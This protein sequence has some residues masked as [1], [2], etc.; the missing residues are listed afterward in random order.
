M[1]TKC[2]KVAIE[3]SK[4]NVLEKNVF[5]KELRDIQ[6]NSYKACNKAI[7]YLY[8]NDMTN[9]LQKEV[10]I[11]KQEDKELYGKSFGAWIE[12]RMNEYMPGALSSNVAQTRQFVKNRYENDKK[13]LLRGEISLS[14]FKRNMPILVHNNSYKIIETPKG[15]GIELGLFNLKKQ[16]E[17]GVKRIK[18]TFPKLGGSEKATIRRLFDKSYKQGAI[19][20]IYNERKKKWMV[21]ISYTFNSKELETN[22]NLVMGIDLGI[23]K[24]ATMSI[25][26]VEKEDYLLMSFKEKSIDGTELIH[27]RQKIESRRK[28]ASIASKW[29][30]ENNTG[31][32]YKERTK[33]QNLLGDKYH[34]FRETYNHKISRYI[35]DLAIKYKVGLIQME[36]LSGFSDQQEDSLLRNWSYYDLQQKV[37]YKAKEVGIE[38]NFINPKHTSQ[39]CSRCGNI[40]KD[41]RK[42]QK[43]FKC[44]V[45]D[46]KENADINASKNI[47]I[48]NIEAIIKE[49]KKEPK[50]EVV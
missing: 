36:D 35:V 10:G 28:S 29:S 8:N 32:G 40:D 17:L 25:Y 44:L 23:S 45:C 31:R 24:I 30:S 22:N 27:T 12:N 9:L 43:D 14:S 38:V 33:L 19:Q 26:D 37:E 13:K 18:F 16:K 48:P 4:D 15:M 7:T 5:F 50:K 6:Y 46:H 21:A 11:P 2:I 3:Y 39:R 1:P 34:R 47:A 42:T 49:Y 20:I 41:N